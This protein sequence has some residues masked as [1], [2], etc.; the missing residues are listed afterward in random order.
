MAP[1]KEAWPE[2]MVFSVPADARVTVGD[3]TDLLRAVRR[4]LIALSRDD[5]GNVPALF[6]GHEPDSSPARSG[7]HKHIFL[8]SADVDGDGITDRLIVA[9]PWACDRSFRGR[10]QDRALFHRIVSSVEAVRAGK[11][12]VIKLGPPAELCPGDGL[13]GPAT[14]WESRTPYRPTRHARRRKDLPVAVSEDV[15]AECGR[16][17]LPRPEIELLG[18]TTGPS[19]GGIAA[20]VRLRFSVVVRGPILLGRDSHFGGGLFWAQLPGSRC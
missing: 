15:I 6:S 4:A 14:V 12:G 2:V 5:R 19:G 16:R 9:T 10:R 3:R 1:V 18:L 13:I 7:Q 20:H 17:A 11:L 8:A